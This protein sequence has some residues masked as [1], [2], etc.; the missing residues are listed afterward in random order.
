MNTAG[1]PCQ[2]WRGP[3]SNGMPGH[4]FYAAASNC[5]A[6]EF[7]LEN[8]PA[9]Q[10]DHA[11]SR[12]ERTLSRSV[13]A[14]RNSG[15]KPSALIR[16]NDEDS[17]AP[18]RQRRVRTIRMVGLVVQDVVEL[19]SASPELI[20]PFPRGTLQNLGVDI[21]IARSAEAV[22]RDVA[23]IGLTGAYAEDVLY[24]VTSDGVR[25]VLM[26]ATPSQFALTALGVTMSAR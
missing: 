11:A 3:P 24:V 25:R 13:N 18:P 7:F 19:P 20:A 10:D 26:A 15:P 1:K 17:E 12:N 2:R 22:R 9:G 14:G 4:R 23:P 5:L 21:E 8:E 16:P 6:C